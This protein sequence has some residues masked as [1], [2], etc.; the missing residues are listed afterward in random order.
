MIRIY[1]DDSGTHASSDV[2]VYAAVLATDALWLLFEAQWRT[3]LAE[4]LPG[5]SALSRFH[6][7][8]CDAGIGEFVRYSRAE[9]DAVTHDFRE[10]IMTSDIH[11]RAAS[12]PVAD[13]DAVIT[14]RRRDLAGNA[15]TECFTA[16]AALVF[17]LISDRLVDKEARLVFNNAPGREELQRKLIANYQR[18]YTDPKPPASP[19]RIVSVSFESSREAIPLQAADMIAWESNL[20]ARQ[21]SVPGVTGPRPHFK[22]LVDTGRFLGTLLSRP[23]IEEIALQLDAHL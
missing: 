1:F 17:E 9:R 22:Q 13:W 16:A 3:K 10:I 7:Y 5:K 2:V 21:K 20:Y 6:M 11:G 12:I 8:D 18:V 15:E 4:P 19:V 14:G 23:R